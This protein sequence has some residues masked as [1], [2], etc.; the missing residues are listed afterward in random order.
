MLLLV[1]TSVHGKQGFS[2]LTQEL[3]EKIGSPGEGKRGRK[4][5]A[6]YFPRY[7]LKDV[8]SIAEAIWTQNAGNPFD[9]LDVAKSVGQSPT[10][11]TFIARL[12]ASFRYG[13]TEGSPTTKVI[14]LTALGSS[15]VAPIAG[16]DV[17]AQLR[18]ALMFSPIFQ[19]VLSWM[20][21]KPI[22]REDVLRNTL[23]K[24]PELGG[25]GIPR[26][27]ADEFV[28]V[29]MQNV[30]DYGLSDDVQG[31]KYLRLD[32]LSSSVIA[33]QELLNTGDPSLQDTEQ[34]TVLGKPASQPS[35][36]PVI[37]IPKQIFVAHGKNRKPLDQL[38]KILTRFKVPYRVAQE[39]PNSGRPVSMKVAELMK[40]CTSGVF[41]FTADEET[42]DLQ[43]EKILRPSDNVVYE[44]GAASVLYGN[45]IVI[46]K[47][48]GVKFA[49]DFSDIGYIS[50]DRDRLDAKAADLMLELITLGFVQLTP[51]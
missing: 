30:A 15:I 27:D 24:S 16:A 34:T 4:A 22:P 1:S 18:K 31:T 47:E 32:K 19:K 35:T 26:E 40:Q 5:G 3:V 11:S 42:T 45:K 51:T 2:E 36:A 20:D 41:I 9:I 10:A 6:I 28:R 7:P 38:E 21:R 49:S 44:L 13:L 33:S 50:F 43:G 23:M 37:Q 8:L 29:F 25:F 17:N 12:A 14:S 46:F 39:E 48:E